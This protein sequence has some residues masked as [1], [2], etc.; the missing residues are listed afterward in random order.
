MTAAP[1]EA[2]RTYTVAQLAD[3]LQIDPRTVR[4][5]AR[6]GT[7]PSLDFGPRTIRFTETHLDTILTTS[8]ATPPPE[9]TTRRRTRRPS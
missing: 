5:K 2:P 9:R 6:T 7:W 4:T 1:T 8:E 3:I